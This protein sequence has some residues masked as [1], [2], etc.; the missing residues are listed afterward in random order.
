MQ[1]FTKSQWCQGLSEYRLSA[2]TLDGDVGYEHA[3]PEGGM[4]D[5]AAPLI[6]GLLYRDTKVQHLLAEVRRA[7]RCPP[8]TPQHREE[9]SS[10]EASLAIVERSSSILAN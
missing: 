9:N 3:R 1:L 8:R 10:T 4:R 7:R 5:R 6:E 2:K